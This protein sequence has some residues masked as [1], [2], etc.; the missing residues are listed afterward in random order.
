MQPLNFERI[1]KQTLQRYATIII[2]ESKQIQQCLPLTGSGINQAYSFFLF[3][4]DIDSILIQSK[5]IIY[6]FSLL[7]LLL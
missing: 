6:L 7:K 5:I 2:T 1:T 4:N 3:N